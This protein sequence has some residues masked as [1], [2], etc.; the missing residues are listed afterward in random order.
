MANETLTENLVYDHFKSDPLFS[1]K[2]V[3]AILERQQ[4]INHQIDELLKGQSKG[5]GT[6]QGRPDFILSF[7]TN[8]NYLIAIECKAEIS[9]H[10]SKDKSKLENIRDYAVDGVLHYAKALSKSYDVLAIAVSGQSKDDL[11]VSHY[12]WKKDADN[13]IEKTEDRILLSISSYLKMFRNE[14]FSDNLLHINIVDKAI[15]LNELFHAYSIQENDRCTMVSAVLLALTSESFKAGY[16]KE[17][18]I[19]SLTNSLLSA[20]NAVTGYVNNL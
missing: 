9:K 19:E 15:Y 17:P 20:I 2:T 5:K 10:E 8:S 11:C 7:P 13:Y 12:L 6:G 1:D 16:V 3:K 4:S 18:T 14:H